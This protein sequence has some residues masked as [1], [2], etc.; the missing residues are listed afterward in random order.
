L[1]PAGDG[2][3][4]GGELAFAPLGLVYL[5]TSCPNGSRHGLHSSAALRLNGRGA[6]SAERDRKGG[7]DRL[8]QL[9]KT[10]IL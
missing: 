1:G 5:S 8:V 6:D 2:I 9:S 7:R 10:I 4:A 3:V